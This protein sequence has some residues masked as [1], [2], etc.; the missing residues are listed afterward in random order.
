MHSGVG[1][2]VHGAKFQEHE[3]LAELAN[4]R[5]LKQDRALR[6]EFDCYPDADQNRREQHKQ[7]ETSQNVNYSLH[8]VRQFLP[9]AVRLELVIGLSVR[10]SSILLVIHIY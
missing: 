4:S 3:W 10:R 9:G 2:R 1:I 8:K 6:R 5:L 7:T